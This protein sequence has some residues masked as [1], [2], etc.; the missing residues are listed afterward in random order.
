MS[1]PC[2]DDGDEKVRGSPLDENYRVVALSRCD[3]Y[4]LTFHLDQ[5]PDVSKEYS[6]YRKRYHHNG[7]DMQVLA[8]LEGWFRYQI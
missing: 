8:G 3:D 7:R 6:T 4:T 1:T 2:V 5:L